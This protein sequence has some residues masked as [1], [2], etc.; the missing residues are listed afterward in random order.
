MPSGH[1]RIQVVTKHP[2][3]DLTGG[4]GSAW[5]AMERMTMVQSR[6]EDDSN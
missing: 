1:K 5:Y 4:E 3:S 6:G 2:E